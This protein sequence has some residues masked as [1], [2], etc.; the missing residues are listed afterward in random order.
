MK[1]MRMVFYGRIKQIEPRRVVVSKTNFQK[2]R[3]TQFP[4]LKKG[5]IMIHN[6]H[7]DP[8]NME[9]RRKMLERDH[10]YEQK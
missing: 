5:S 4:W 8:E 6:S 9:S 1:K 2:N 3:N 10:S 7:K